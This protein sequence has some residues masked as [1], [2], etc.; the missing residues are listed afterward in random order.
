MLNRYGAENFLVVNF[1]FKMKPKDIISVLS[2]GIFLDGEGFQFIGCSSSGLKKR[3]CYMMKG[4]ANEVE[5]VRDTECGLFAKITSIPKKL[6]GIGLLFSNATQTGIDI[7]SDCVK[8]I[9][10]VTSEDGRYNF[11]DGCG[12]IGSE[13]HRK[14]VE[15]AR[16]AGLLPD[17]YTPSVLQIH[18][19]GYKGVVTLDPKLKTDTI[20]IR[21]SMVKFESGTRLFS[22]VWLCNHSKPYSIGYLNKQYIILLSGLGVPDEVLLKK[23][24]SYYDLML[25]LKQD[26]Q[27]SFDQLCISGQHALAAQVAIGNHAGEK[28]Q[29]ALSQIQRKFLGKISKLSIQ[30]QDSRNVFGIC[31]ASGI[32]DYGEC[33]FRP[34]INGEPRTVSGKVIVAK[35]PCYFLG[36]VRVLVAVDGGRT[37]HLSHLVDCIVFPTTGAR[38][39]PDE[40]TGSDL[41]GDEYFVC[42]DEELSI[43]RLKNPTDFL[44]LAKASMSSHHHEWKS[45]IEYLANQVNMMG[46]LNSFFLYWAESKGVQSTECQQVGQL[47]SR[48]VDASKTGDKFVIPKHLCPPKERDPQLYES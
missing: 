1:N 20:F 44:A 40:I 39:H 37:K 11:T 26:P 41:D 45:C 7:E 24:R 13:L 16:L 2:K 6:K 9:A 8:I 27:V 48:S 31:D 21:R 15:G 5:R 46:L 17:G 3:S 33:F 47:F 35:N 42:W 23:Q 25:S 29:E 32:L 30:I 43:D 34:T 36:D 38:P 22:Q 14:I 12:A 19:K 10:D 4:T 28:V 18:L